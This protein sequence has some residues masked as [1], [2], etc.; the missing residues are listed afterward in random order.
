MSIPYNDLGLKMLFHLLR[1]TQSMYNGYN[2]K[3]MYDFYL[4]H[5]NTSDSLHDMISQFSEFLK[6][7]QRIGVVMVRAKH[8]QRHS[9]SNIFSY[10]R[11][12]PKPK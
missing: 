7:F 5:S 4:A 12:K 6:P 1:S 2:M 10:Y 9:S 3:E 8:I 11:F